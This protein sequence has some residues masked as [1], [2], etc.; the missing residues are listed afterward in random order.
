MLKKLLLLSLSAVC[1]AACTQESGWET[2]QQSEGEGNIALNAMMSGFNSTGTRTVVSADDY[3]CTWKAG[4]K[5]GMFSNKINGE[6][7]TPSQLGLTLTAGG[8]TG[9]AVFTG[10][11]GWKMNSAGEYNYVAYYPYNDKNTR[12]SIV[13]DYNGQTQTANNST[14][15]LGDYDFMYSNVAVPASPVSATF[16][17]SHINAILH[18]KITLPE[19]YNDRKFRKVSLIAEEEI[20]TTQATYDIQSLIANGNPTITPAQTDSKVDMEFGDEGISGTD[21]TLDAW[22][23]MMPT[24][25]NGK[26]IT[27]KLY[28]RFSAIP[29][30]EGKFTASSNQQAATIDSYNVALSK[31]EQSLPDKP[32]SGETLNV[33]L[34]GHSFGIDCTEYLPAITVAAGVTDVHYGRFYQGNCSMAQHWGHWTAEDT[35]SYYDAAAGK[36]SWSSSSRSS[37]SVVAGTPW[38]III[39]QTSITSA[40]E[41]TYSTFKDPLRKMV[42]EVVEMCE[43]EHGKTPL[44]GWNMFWGYNSGGRTGLQEYQLIVN[45]TKDMLADNTDVRLVIPTGTAVQNVR[46]TSAYDEATMNQ[47]T[48]DG[49][50]MGYGIGRYVTACTW[51]QT[52]IA[53]I[54]G[55]SVE[56]SSSYMPTSKTTYESGAT[57][58]V[59]STNR[60]IL[61]KCAKAAALHPFE[62]TTID[63]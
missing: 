50:H 47:L 1:L 30:L 34:F 41:G 55:V 61:W 52:I 28:D 43:K 45:G 46:G 56:A 44:I 25:W 54:Y 11:T 63:E 4:D 2:A 29:L 17:F 36:S 8:G 20:F 15:H 6:T 42:N 14:A 19:E 49:Y 33:L 62:V 37:K 7:Q 48:R 22:L 60:P 35:Y 12:E 21:G 24:Q 40:Q 9:E 31:S 51:F 13:L 23:M 58:A 59:T 16:E 53:P 38:D 18:L 3:S 32:K 27:V 10:A 5:M 57:D 26:E 39:F